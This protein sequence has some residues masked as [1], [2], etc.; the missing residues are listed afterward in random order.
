MHPL[1][2]QP[3]QVKGAQPMLATWAV[4]E[5]I[6]PGHFL[7]RLA[8]YTVPLVAAAVVVA[9]ALAAGVVTLVELSFF[10]FGLVVSA[11]KM[12]WGVAA[13][14]RATTLVSN[15]ARIRMVDEDLL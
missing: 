8:S 1:V 7:Q 2:M 10:F 6:P 15:V 14:C 4:V 5:E 3:N 12:V 11:R 13:S 9:V